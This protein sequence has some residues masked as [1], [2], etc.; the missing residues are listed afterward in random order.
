VQGKGG[1]GRKSPVCGRCRRARHQGGAAAA[2][3]VPLDPSLAEELGRPGPGHLA[4]ND[5]GSPPTPILPGLGLDEAA[6]KGQGCG[7]FRPGAASFARP[8]TPSTPST[9]RRAKTLRVD[10]RSQAVRMRAGP[11]SENASSSRIDRFGGPAH[12]ARGCSGQ[13]GDSASG[14]RYPARALPYRGGGLRFH[15]WTNYSGGAAETR[16]TAGGTAPLMS[17]AVRI[18]PEE[19]WSS[20]PVPRRAHGGVDRY[21][22]RVVK[23]H[24]VAA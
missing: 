4:E 22:K 1:G 3:T 16:W 10:R 12:A 17:G 11:I 18:Q 9:P 5:T 13:E 20:E 19:R 7:A 2:T 21:A 8:G 24:D 15:Q 6:A 23:L 14:G